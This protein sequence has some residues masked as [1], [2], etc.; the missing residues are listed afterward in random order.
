MKVTLGSVRGKVAERVKFA[1][2]RGN[3]DD[4]FK[5]RERGTE[6]KTVQPNK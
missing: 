4:V 2:E 5:M 1:C 6:T 3:D